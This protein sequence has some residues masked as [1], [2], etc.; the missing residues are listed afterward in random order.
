MFKGEKNAVT[1]I[2][3]P[4]LQNVGHFERKGRRQLTKVLLFL[5][6]W[7]EGWAKMCICSYI[8]EMACSSADKS[9]S[10]KLGSEE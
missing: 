9:M 6:V 7:F 1:R 8:I 2:L 4:V 3:I 10:E 5:E